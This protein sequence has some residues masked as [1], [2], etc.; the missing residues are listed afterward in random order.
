MRQQHSLQR[1]PAD[2]SSADSHSRRIIPQNTAAD[3]RLDK[4]RR[5]DRA[6]RKRLKERQKQTMSTLETL[7]AEIELLKS[8]NE[9]LKQENVLVKL[10]FETRS[11]ELDELRD[12]FQDLNQKFIKKL[13]RNK[14]LKIRLKTLEAENG[15]SL[16]AEIIESLKERN[17]MSETQSNV[18]EQLRRK[19]EILGKEVASMKT[20]G[21]RQNLDGSSTIFIGGFGQYGETE[22]VIQSSH[23][24][25]LPSSPAFPTGASSPVI[26]ELSPQSYQSAGEKDGDTIL[27]KKKSDNLLRRTTSGWSLRELPEYDEDEEEHAQRRMPSKKESVRYCKKR[28][29][30]YSDPETQVGSLSLPIGFAVFSAP[31]SP[32]LDLTLVEMPEVSKLGMQFFDRRPSD[33]S[34]DAAVPER[35]NRKHVYQPPAN[36]PIFSH[37]LM[38][39]DNS[40]VKMVEETIMRIPELNVELHITPKE[41]KVEILSFDRR[42]SDTSADAAVP[43]QENPKQQVY[44]PAANNP[45]SSH[46]LMRVDNFQVK[47]AEETIIKIPRLNLTLRIMPKESTVEIL[48]FDRPPDTS[49]DVA[50]PVQENSEQEVYQPAANNPISSHGLRN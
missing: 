48:S 4:K 27:G 6:Y 29:Q 31:P 11:K 44:Q 5:N 50:V 23:A 34:A 36:N 21:N 3:H 41:S 30:A 16:R 14:K 46:D 49:A 20:C 37:D 42:P 28:K 2:T 13:E 8:E 9:S 24:M 26:E 32:F 12:T 22:G 10:S 39:I 40:Q 7:E 35:E 45:I 17:G 38:T 19:V 47:M 33:A 15:R 1:Q 18:L 43:V 25:M